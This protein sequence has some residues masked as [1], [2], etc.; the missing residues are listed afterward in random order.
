MLGKTFENGL[1]VLVEL[2]ILLKVPVALLTIV[3]G[4]LKVTSS[5]DRDVVNVVNA[6]TIF[7]QAKM[8]KVT[9]MGTLGRADIGPTIMFSGK[10]PVL[11][12]DRSTV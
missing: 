8:G 3:V 10:I 4:G 11:L 1:L 12:P 9:I 6:Q 2:D 5:L 7:P